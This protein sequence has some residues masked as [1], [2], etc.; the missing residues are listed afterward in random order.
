M[1]N[2]IKSFIKSVTGIAQI[3][4]QSNSQGGFPPPTFNNLHPPTINSLINDYKRYIYTC[5][6][7]NAYGCCNIELKLYVTTSKGEKK[8]RLKTKALTDKKKEY[9][10]QKRYNLNNVNE[11]EEV[12]E[13][14]VLDL[15]YKANHTTFL[16]GYKLKEL[17][18]YI[19]SR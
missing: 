9:L 7:L 3:G 10:L 8:P 1:K 5:V 18:F 6:N 4:R 14:P 19:P 2:Y 12:V 16:N 17:T 11:I 13:H 15:L